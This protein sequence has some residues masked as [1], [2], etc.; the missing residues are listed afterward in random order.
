[1]LSDIVQKFAMVGDVSIHYY[2]LIHP[3][4]YVT[5]TFGSE[6]RNRTSRL[7]HGLE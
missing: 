3:L 5:V 4:G 2:I 7:L 1:V 6:K